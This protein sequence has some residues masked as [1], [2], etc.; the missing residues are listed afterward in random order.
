MSAIFSILEV[1]LLI[2]AVVMSFNII[3]FVHEL[4]HFLAAKWRGLQVD[5]FQIWFG[6]PIWKKDIGGVQYGLGWIPAGGFVAL[7]QM[8]SM[9]S[10]EGT[11]NERNPLPPISPLDKIIVAF[12]GPL[13]SMLLALLAGVMVWGIGKPK[14]FIPTQVVGYVVEG[15]PAH[16]AGIR[17]GDKIL[18]INGQTV[19]GFQGTL[20]SI[21]EGIVLSKG[22]QIEFTVA[23]PGVAEPLKITSEFKTQETKWFQRSGL[24][25]VGI[26][27]EAEFIEMGHAVK[28]S[29]AEKA[30]FKEGDRLVTM[31]GQSYKNADGVVKAIKAGG[32]QPIVFEITREG[33][34]LTITVSPVVPLSPP[35]KGPML[36]LSF[37]G[38]PHIEQQIVHPGPVSQV[39]DSL[40]MMWTTVTSVLSRD[41]SIGV[42]HLSGPVGIAKLQY[43]LLQT[44]DGW[45]RILAFMVLFNV[46]LAVLNMMPFPV[47]DGGHITLA[48]LEKIFG[49]PVKAKP[50]EILQTA[51]ALALISLMLFVT[52]KDIGDS[53]GNDAPKGEEVVFP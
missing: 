23:R 16:Q 32:T 20:D 46:N 10:I 31:N 15:G 38:S 35:G 22:K 47:L 52:S 13:F 17:E 39:S 19:N 11:N 44:D 40:R 26:G 9:E 18:A 49:R 48:I 27:P 24:R 21:T 5:R 33:K 8:A 25:Q 2:F 29:P 7:P 50:L 45:R 37:Y 12:A 42:S 34:P 36:G 6:R 41:S 53:F 30:G 4:G 1:I 3:I 51:C 14:D 43:Q 28:G